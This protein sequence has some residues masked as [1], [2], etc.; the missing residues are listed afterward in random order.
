MIH[1]LV[2]AGFEYDIP[3]S[4]CEADPDVKL[5]NVLDEITCSVCRRA[6]GIV[7]GEIDKHKSGEY[8]I[9]W[10]SNETLSDP[11]DVG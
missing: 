1:Y 9:D 7:D 10:G 5:S 3:V 6:K 11:S 8:Q 2:Y 4:Y